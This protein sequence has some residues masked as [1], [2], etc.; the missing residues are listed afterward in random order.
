V[1][2]DSLVALSA[3]LFALLGYWRGL[4]RKLAGLASLVIASVAASTVGARLAA[5]ASQ[6]WQADS[7]GVT[8]LCIIIGW[9]ALYVVCRIVLGFIARKLGSG[10]EGKPARWNR[11]LGA[12]FGAIE[13]GLICWFVVATLDAMPEDKRAAWM[14]KVHEELKHSAFAT[15]AHETSP[16]A[17]FELTPLIADISDLVEKPQALASL[18]QEPEV[19]PLLNSPSVQAIMQ[20][21]ALVEELRQGRV[22]RFLADPK[23]RAALEDP[24]VRQL[25]RAATLRELVHR[26]AERARASPEQPAAPVK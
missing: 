20:D 10:P 21:Q 15:L 8:V 14:P 16:F 26:A 1:S 5:Y 19:A 9:L 7:P 13:A 17:F 25:L 11:V 2:L 6:R 18:G 3:L 22:A 23:V 24:A 12:L 4:L